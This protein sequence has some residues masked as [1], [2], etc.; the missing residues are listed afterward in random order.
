[1]RPVASGPRRLRGARRGSRTEVEIE[2]ARQRAG[3]AE[4]DGEAPGQRGLE[5]RTGEAQG[6]HVL[7]EP[8][9]QVVLELD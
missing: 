5:G 6:A 4:I 1:M 8:S 2:P 9:A 7:R 3:G